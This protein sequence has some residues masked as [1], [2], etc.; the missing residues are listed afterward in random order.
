[1]KSVGKKCTSMAKAIAKR[2]VIAA[3]PVAMVSAYATN[4]S[5]PTPP[6]LAAYDWA[7]VAEINVSPSTVGV[8]VSPLYGQ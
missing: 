2:S 5:I 7:P 6:R 4:M 3:L 8:A 1:M